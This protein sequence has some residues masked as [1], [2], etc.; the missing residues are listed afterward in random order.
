MHQLGV[1]VLECWRRGWDSNPERLLET[2]NLLISRSDQTL[3][4]LVPL[5]SGTKKVQNASTANGKIGTIRSDC[6]GGLD[7]TTHVLRL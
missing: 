5:E 4:P 2:R 6:T 7:S 1:G 3:E